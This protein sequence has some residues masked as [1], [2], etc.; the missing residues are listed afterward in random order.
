MFI[1]VNRILN[2]ITLEFVFKLDENLSFLLLHFA[3]F[4]LGNVISWKL[5]PTVLSLKK[6]TGTLFSF[7]ILRYHFVRKDFVMKKK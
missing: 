1:I 7:V 6:R 3:Q 4:F 5:N 2:Y